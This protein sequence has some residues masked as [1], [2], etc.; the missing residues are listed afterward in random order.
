MYSLLYPHIVWPRRFK[1]FS[2]S[3]ILVQPIL[4]SDL[5]ALLVD[6]LLHARCFLPSTDVVTW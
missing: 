6:H 1:A 5:D 3:N 4:L 2:P